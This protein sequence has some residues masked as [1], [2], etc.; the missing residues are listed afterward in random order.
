MA[1]RKKSRAGARTL[2]RNSPLIIVSGNPPRAVVRD[3]MSDHAVAILYMRKD[4]G[5][6]RVHG[7]G[8]ADLDLA[9]VRGEVRIRG[10]KQHT[11]VAM[12]ALPDG[13][14]HMYSTQGK[15]LWGELPDGNT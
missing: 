9:T 11:R 2:K 6:Y 4:D 7:F 14:L 13:S 5:S 12:D 1:K 8:D 15:P 3:R 10:L